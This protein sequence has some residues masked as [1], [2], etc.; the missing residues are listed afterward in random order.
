L[1]LGA[2]AAAEDVSRELLLLVLVLPK[3]QGMEVCKQIHRDPSLNGLPIAVLK[4]LSQ[5][6]ASVLGLAKAT[7]DQVRL[8]NP[9]AT[10]AEIKQLLS[11]KSTPGP[12]EGVIEVGDL[13]IDPI[14]YRVTRAGRPATLTK[15]EFKLL[16]YLA[17]RPNRPFTRHQLFNAV[18]GGRRSSNP[19]VVDVYIWRVRMKIE[20]DPQHPAHLKTL[21]GRGYQFV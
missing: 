18:W 4:L 14:S 1:D 5:D 10:V 16:Y 2:K 13:I 3:K 6:V 15:L 9:T 7:H 8:L 20:P 12:L 11:C 21:I 19:R 17:A